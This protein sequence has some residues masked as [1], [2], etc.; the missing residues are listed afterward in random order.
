MK[1][2]PIGMRL[3][4][5]ALA[6]LLALPFAQAASPVEAKR[7]ARTVTRT[8]ADPAPI[9]LPNAEVDRVAATPY[10]SAIAVG[11]PKRARIRDVNLRLIGLT[12]TFPADAHVL[13][14]GPGGQTALLMAWAGGGADV[15]GVTLTLDDEAAAPLPNDDPLQSGAYRPAH[16]PEGPIVFAPPAPNPGANAALSAFDGTNPNGAWRLFVM[17]GEGKTDEG[18]FAGGWELE[19][20]TKV[21]ARNK[22]R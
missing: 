3:G 9:T 11:G 2:Y 5:V 12:H 8:F 22:R 13:L 19:I 18:V 15:D 14:V 10:P 21:K 16:Y 6:A 20:T 4:L 17:D 1:R 7:R